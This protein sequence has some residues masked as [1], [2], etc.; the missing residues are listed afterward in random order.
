[1]NSKK[2]QISYSFLST[3]KNLK[4]NPSLWQKFFISEEIVKAIRNFFYQ[5]KFH[6][7]ETPLLVPSVIP[8]SYLEVFTTQLFT[9]KGRS[10]KLFLTTSPE[11]SLKKLLVAGVGNCFEVTKS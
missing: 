10:K 3:W 9:A 5:R 7:V 4:S 8:E 11:A 6:E 1:M 2:K